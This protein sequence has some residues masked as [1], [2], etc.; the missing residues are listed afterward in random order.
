MEMFLWCSLAVSSGSPNAT[1]SSCTYDLNATSA[2]LV[3][4]SPVN[5]SSFVKLLEDDYAA[6]QYLS[7]VQLVDYCCLNHCHHCCRLVSR[8]VV[9]RDF[10]G[11]ELVANASDACQAA[12]WCCNVCFRPVLLSCGAGAG[13]RCVQGLLTG[14][15]PFE[16]MSKGKTLWEHLSVSERHAATFDVAML[17]VRLQPH[18]SLIDS[19]IFKV[20]NS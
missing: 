19:S 2:A 10:D 13:T 18:C 16:L 15:V 20:T 9:N 3:S 6:M 11:S 8:D 1:P 5:M 14:T 4:S 12:V 17:Q 7:E